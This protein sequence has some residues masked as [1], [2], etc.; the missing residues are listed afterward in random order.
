MSIARPVRRRE[1]ARL[2]TGRGTYADD[3]DLP[4]Q[5]HAAFVRSPYAHGMV[6]GIDLDAARVAPG[7]LGLFTAAEDRKSVV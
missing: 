4:G 7:V 6:R 3:I 2:L 5:A 1:D